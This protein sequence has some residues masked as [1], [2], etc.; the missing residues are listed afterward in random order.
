MI[1]HPGDTFMDPAPFV[2]SVGDFWG[3]PQTRP[4]TQARASLANSMV[5]IDTVES[6]E[7]QLEHFMDMLRLCRNDNLGVRD[8]IPGLMLR[9][10]KDQECCDFIKWWADADE[11]S[12]KN[13]NKKHADAFE[14]VDGSNNFYDLCHS[15]CL[16]AL[17]IK[18]LLDL[19]RLQG[20]A[21]CLGTKVPREIVD[22]IQTSVPPS[23]IFRANPQLMHEG[24][25]PFGS[26]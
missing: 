23:P 11:W 7:A 22:V 19:M 16:I 3:I 9:L 8:I 10:N 14:P 15:V 1:N 12:A 24:A 25:G 20:S 13:W 4:Y 5:S 2:N 17:K 18:L 21:F 26:S 6:A